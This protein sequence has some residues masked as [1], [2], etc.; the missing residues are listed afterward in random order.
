[1]PITVVGPPLPGALQQSLT[2][3]AKDI[4]ASMVEAANAA[5]ATIL[6]RGRADISGAGR[7]GARWTTGL[8]ADVE[9]KPPTSVDIT[10]RQAVPYWSV[11]QYGKTIHGKPLL[12]IPLSFAREAQGVR[13]R[14]FPG[15]LFRVDRKSGGAPLLLSADDKQ[16]KYHGQSEV[17][18]PKKFHLVEICHDVAGQLGQL[19]RVTAAGR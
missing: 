9:D 15:R 18:I 16:P 1:M 14:D 10:V 2:K 19:Y 13:A 3:A 7:F 11:F 6:S 17:T 5:S 4:H 8:T 12:W